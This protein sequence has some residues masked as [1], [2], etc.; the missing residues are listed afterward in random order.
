MTE[1]YTH[2]RGFWMKIIIIENN[3]KLGDSGFEDKYGF[4]AIL[5]DLSRKYRCPKPECNDFLEYKDSS[6]TVLVCPS[7]GFEKPAPES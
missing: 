3:S 6:R 7:C 5:G 4:Y 1:V 2:D